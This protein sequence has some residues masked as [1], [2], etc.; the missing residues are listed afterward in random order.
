MTVNTYFPDLGVP[1]LSFDNVAGGFIATSHLIELGHREIA[2]IGPQF[3]RY[4]QFGGRPPGYELALEQHGVD[5]NQEWIIESEQPKNQPQMPSAHCSVNGGSTGVFAST[6]A[7][8]PRH[9]SGS[10]R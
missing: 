3:P 10:A 8:T 1:F 5:V 6:D 2:F 4:N 9:H 7:N